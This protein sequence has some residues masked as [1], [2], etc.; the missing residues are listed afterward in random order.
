MRFFKQQNVKKKRKDSIPFSSKVVAYDKGLF[1][2]VSLFLVL[3]CLSFKANQAYNCKHNGTTGKE[4][5]EH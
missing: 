5:Q 1:F 4:F 3:V 2:F